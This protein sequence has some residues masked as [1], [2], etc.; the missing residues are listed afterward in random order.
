MPR[1]TRDE[2]GRVAVELVRVRPH[3]T[4]FRFLENEGE[5]VVEFLVGPEPYE[6][7]G[8]AVDFGSEMRL[9]MGAHPRIDPVGRDN[10]VMLVTQCL[11]INDFGLEFQLHA[12]RNSAFLKKLQQFSTADAAETVAG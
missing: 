6:L 3:P 4:V 1:C 12:E 2:G 8:A 10:K 9:E 5:G 11:D 7:A